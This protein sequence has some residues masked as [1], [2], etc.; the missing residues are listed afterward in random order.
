MKISRIYYLWRAIFFFPYPDR[1]PF[2]NQTVHGRVPALSILMEINKLIIVFIWLCVKGKDFSTCQFF[3]RENWW[4]IKDFT[5]FFHIFF[6]NFWKF[7]ETQGFLIG[8]IG[9]ICKEM[10]IFEFFVVFYARKVQLFL[11]GNLQKG[12][13]E[14]DD[15]LNTYLRVT[16]PDLLYK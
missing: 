7:I 14:H 15:V 16:F 12:L 3:P 11:C 8:K 2:V 4:K 10:M 5:L 1:R 13:P 6:A 9:R